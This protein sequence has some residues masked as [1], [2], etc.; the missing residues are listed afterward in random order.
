MI[1]Y[2]LLVPLILF[3][4]SAI[5]GEP[6]FTTIQH[7]NRLRFYSVY[8]QSATID[9]KFLA[10]IALY[11]TNDYEKENDLYFDMEITTLQMIV[12]YA[13]DD[14]LQI[15][16]IVPIYHIYGGFMDNFLD[17]FHDTTGLLNGKRHDIDGKNRVFYTLDHL[18]AKKSPYTVWGNIQIEAKRVF[19]SFFDISQALAF[20]IKLPT[21][22]SLDGF[23]SGK[24]D[25]MIG[26][27][28]QKRW[29]DDTLW[30]NCNIVRNG[31]YHLDS[32]A[33]SR[34]IGYFF[35]LG[36][37]HRYQKDRSWYLAYRYASSPFRSSH[38][39]M[40][41]VSNVIDL[42]WRIE[43]FDLFISENLAPFYNS[44]DIT[45]GVAYSF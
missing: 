35:Y 15:R 41:S 34:D 36:W 2:R 31:E 28:A 4:I 33:S 42:A 38:N 9:K 14:T 39:A 43:N 12:G 16:A 18:F 29:Q 24:A 11:E 23:G 6:L 13:P 3:C 44:P 5:A 10:N 1:I 45:I 17:W 19:P 40:D 25:I 8:P 32:L 30:I 21:S 37:E 27:L 26:W 7:P 20:G 22:A